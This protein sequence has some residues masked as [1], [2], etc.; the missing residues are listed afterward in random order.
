MCI[1]FLPKIVDVFAAF[2]LKNAFNG[3]FFEPVILHNPFP[4]LP[5]VSFVVGAF[6]R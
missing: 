1:V 6:L 5:E 3:L 2:F 4:S